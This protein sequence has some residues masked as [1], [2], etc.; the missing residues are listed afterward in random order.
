[1]EKVNINDERDVRINK[2]KLLQKAGIN[3][4]PTTAERSHHIGDVIADFKKLSNKEKVVS[5]VGRI[6]LLRRHGGSTFARIQDESGTIQLFFNK[7]I[8]GEKEYKLLKEIDVADFLAI[9]G[10]CFTTKTKEKTIQ[11]QSFQLISKSLRPLPDKFHGLK[12]EEYRYRHR[13]V[14]LIVNEDVR[15]LFR[16]R[17]HFVQSLRSFL[18]DHGFLEVETPV[19]EH[20]PGGAEAEPFITHH[21]SLDIDLYLRIS[22]ELHL[23]RLT[24][25]GYEK[26]YEI[27]KVFRNEGVSTQHLQEFT[28]MEFY[29]AYANNE[30]LMKFVEKMYQYIIK[31]TFG[32][33][34]INSHGH[35]L[36]FSGKWPR[37]DY[38][39]LFLDKSGIDL[40]KV[41]TADQ[42]KKAIKAK[43]I[44]ISIDK[45]SG[46]GR[47]V[48]QVYKKVVRPDLI[49]PS[50]LINHPVEISPLAKRH[51]T[52][53]NIVER[54]QVLILG[55]EVG[56]GFSELNDPIDQ[57]SRFEDQMKLREAGDKE[58]QMIDED[59]I[60]ALEHGMPPTGGFGVG[61]DRLF[62]IL[63]DQPSVRDVVF[64]PTMRPKPSQE[65]DE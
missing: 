27:G 11:V 48:D 65:K 6:R 57:R 42:L 13:Y 10:P 64:F 46:Y 43:K 52:D 5:V 29:W 45:S 15:E 38:R 34:N 33:L 22:L 55:A 7:K 54:H 26:I 8:V 4:F 53:E 18:S 16:K 37:L 12:D 49:Q 20:I 63:S 28:M 47:L 41:R 60:E 35:K 24:V 59:Y 21:N 56:N 58:A 40:S 39:T 17:S 1:M 50:F 62:M 3:P 31:T 51:D 61:I 30:M 32:T 25:G 2:L 44:K 9:T 14:D 36:N 23:K 19:L